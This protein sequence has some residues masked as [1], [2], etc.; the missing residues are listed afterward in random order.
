MSAKTP[1]IPDWGNDDNLPDVQPGGDHER[2]IA[3][4]AEARAQALV[5]FVKWA[6]ARIAKEYVSGEDAVRV[7]EIR[8]VL[9]ELASAPHAD[10]DGTE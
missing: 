3:E 10:A 6:L 9:A 5:S 4:M 1:L 8:A 7:R 2:E